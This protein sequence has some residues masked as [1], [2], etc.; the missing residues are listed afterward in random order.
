MAK[1]LTERA[2]KLDKLMRLR[3]A[4]CEIQMDHARLSDESDDTDGLMVA[5][6]DRLLGIV[7]D[8]QRDMRRTRTLRGMELDDLQRLARLDGIS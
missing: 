7:H 2:A 1:S 6:C 4:I 5:N 3:L 8:M